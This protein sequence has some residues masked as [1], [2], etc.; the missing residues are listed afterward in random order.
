[1]RCMGIGDHLDTVEGWHAAAQ[2]LIWQAELGAVDLCGDGPVD[3]YALT[4]E[5]ARPALAP[6]VAAAG[7]ASVPPAPAR[8]VVTGAVAVAE[9]A[10]GGAN[11]LGELR[12][13]IA[14]F[15]LCEMKRGAKTTVFA[16]GDP[17]ARVMIIGEAPGRDEDT[18]GRPFVGR[19]GQLLDQMLA[20]IGMAR[21]SP[22]TANAVYITNVMPWR[23]PQN[24]DP[25]PDEVAMMLPFLVR[26][27]ALAN[28]DMIVVMGNTPLFAATGGKGITRQRGIWREGFGKPMLPM[29]HPAYLLRNPVA[30]REAWADLLMLKARLEGRD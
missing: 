8:N 1:M 27:V 23:P 16:D 29:V 4:D 3:R 6:R 9:A 22:D 19:A 13:A 11:T 15:D 17:A 30:K 24:R 25:E 5:V 2:A 21:S 10:A 28:P 7:A 18:I 12:A 20:A 14:A 26:H